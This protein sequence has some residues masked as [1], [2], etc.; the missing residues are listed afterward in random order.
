MLPFAGYVKF[1]AVDRKTGIPGLAIT[2]LNKG[3]Q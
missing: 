1:I 2:L 3:I